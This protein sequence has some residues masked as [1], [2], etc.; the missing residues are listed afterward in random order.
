MSYEV[1]AGDSITS[2]AARFGVDARVLA[3]DNTL[4]TNDRLRPGDR[5]TIDNRH[6]APAVRPDGI[7]LNVA[8]RMLFVIRD[9][10]VVRACPVAA[11]RPDWRTPLGTSEV[12]VRQIDPVW[13][14]NELLRR[15]GL[16][17]LIESGPVRRAV[18]EP[19]GRATVVTPWGAARANT[20]L[21]PAGMVLGRSAKAWAARATQQP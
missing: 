13:D 6:I 18:A 12:A 4:H 17:C 9:G 14:V 10:H 21:R 8:Q 2:V 16:A 20:A 7:V 19:A 11:G 3:R 5:L 15:A 1:T